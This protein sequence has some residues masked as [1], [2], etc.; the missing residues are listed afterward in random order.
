MPSD[1]PRHGTGIPSFVACTITRRHAVCRLETALLKNLSISRLTRS[2]LR[3]NAFRSAKTRHGDSELRG[4][5]D[6]PP[7][8]RLPLG[9]RA[10][11]ELVHQQIDEIRLANKCLPICQDTAR[12]FRASWPARSPAATPSAAWR[13]RS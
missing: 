6:H 8:R 5:H 11:E 4:L 13:P 7:P 3:T 1:L 2:D 12:G 9:D 10:L